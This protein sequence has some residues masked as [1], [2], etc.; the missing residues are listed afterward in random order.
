MQYGSIQMNCM[1]KL[2]L[3]PRRDEG[4]NDIQMV[5]IL[6]DL[7]EKLWSSQNLFSWVR[8]KLKTEQVQEWNS[9]VSISVGPTRTHMQIHRPFTKCFR[10]KVNIWRISQMLSYIRQEIVGSYR[11]LSSDHNLALTIVIIIQSFQTSMC[12]LPCELFILHY[13]I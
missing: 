11:M 6:N 1:L 3:K 7:L 9:S 4:S 12:Q 5:L 10:C 2:N 13:F 8:R